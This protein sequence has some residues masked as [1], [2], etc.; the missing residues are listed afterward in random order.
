MQ[1]IDVLD[2]VA[3]ELDPDGQFLVHGNDFH[4]VAA[5]PER[6]AVEVHVVAGVL[7]GDEFPEQVVAVHLRP[8]AERHH[9]GDV[10]FRRAEAVDAGDG[11][12]HDH[13]AAGQQRVGGGVPEPFH[14]LVDGGVLLD[15]GVR[16]GDVGLG[17]VVVVVG[18]EVLH[19]VVRQQF[20]ELVGQLRGEGLVLDHHQGGPLDLLDQPGGGGALAGTRGAQQ[21]HVLFAVLDALGQFGDGRRLVTGRLEL[22]DDLE[23]RNDAVDLLRKTHVSNLPPGTDRNP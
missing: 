22:A 19:R 2:L 20:A 17:L 18:D 14:F 23:G 3:E 5:D 16:L 11:G 8:L 9:A 15:E 1:R 7:H 13:V 12:H 4:G 10:L 6:A 21:H